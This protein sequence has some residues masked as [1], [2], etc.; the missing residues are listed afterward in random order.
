MA[1]VID[2]TT[3]EAL[4]SP[5]P[6][7]RDV[8]SPP[9]LRVPSRA[10]QAR[11]RGWCYTNYDA[12]LPRPHLPGMRY[13]VGGYERCPSSGRMHWQCYVYFTHPQSFSV[14]RAFAPGAHIEPARGDAQVNRTYCLKDAAL[15]GSQSFEHGELPA[16]GKRNDMNDF[17]NL[18]VDGKHDIEVLRA[19]PGHFLRFGRHINHVRQTLLAAQPRFRDVEVVVY[20][21]PTGS[22]KT[23]QV[24]DREEDLYVIPARTVDFNAKIWLDGYHGQDAL[25]L[26]DYRGEY[27]FSLFLQ[28]LDGY[29]RQWEIKGGFTWGTWSRLYITSDRTP[30]AWYPNVEQRYM[31]QMMRRI[32]TVEELADRGDG[33][34]QPPA[35][36]G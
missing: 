34:R 21:G 9:P 8:P 35:A 13:H 2:L 7:L 33:G 17:A 36:E 27:K 18:I 29:R 23:R 11:A 1:D 15:E 25:L 6:L 14:M 31:P 19:M 22:G 5:G 16:Q 12:R 30:R 10:H 28:L 4:A 20:W 3:D 26:D 24:Y 32:N